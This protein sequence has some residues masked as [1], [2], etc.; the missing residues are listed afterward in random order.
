MHDNQIDR[1]LISEKVEAEIL[2]DD[3]YECIEMFQLIEQ[4]NVPEGS[5]FNLDFASINFASTEPTMSRSGGLFND[6]YI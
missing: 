5:I 6:M 2:K 3:L 1:Y 4:N